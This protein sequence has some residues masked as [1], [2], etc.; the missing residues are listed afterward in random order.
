M[1]NPDILSYDLDGTLVDSIPDITLSMN[2]T[3]KEK[4]LPPISQEQMKTFVGNGIPAM[5]ERALKVSLAEIHAPN[6][7]ET[8]Y[9]E[10]LDR[11]KQI[12]QEH[13]TDETRLY[14][15]AKEIV[16]HFS[17]KIQV[18]ITNK[19]E[20]MTR[21]ILNYFGLENAFSVIVGG[22]TL[23]EK[24]P[25]PAVIAYI[26]KK[27]ALQRTLCHIGDSPIDIETAL[28]SNCTAI[29]V[30]WGYSSRQALINAH[31]HYIIDHFNELKE[32]IA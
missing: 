30:S 8:L 26:Y 15:G 31:P 10:I 4:S 7:F 12:Y 16:T 2:M 32:I 17:Y 9:Q 19:A 13:C 6:T 28:A 25:N 21:K 14:T 22:D 1:I 3:L 23:P 18:L 27:T 24:K 29:A 5:V 20:S 11:Y